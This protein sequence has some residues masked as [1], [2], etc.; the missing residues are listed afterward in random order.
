MSNYKE[1]GT[2]SVFYGGGIHTHVRERPS[3][4]AAQDTEPSCSPSGSRALGVCPVITTQDALGPQRVS[5][6][7]WC[8][9]SGDPLPKLD[10]SLPTSHL[11]RYR[12]LVRKYERVF[13]DDFSKDSWQ[14]TPAEI[15]LKPDAVP[16]MRTRFACLPSTTMH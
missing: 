6:T 7:E 5:D 15:K 2:V 9:S 11:K 8:T 14:T 12:E 16:C 4:S 3:H 1:I 13:H 10:A